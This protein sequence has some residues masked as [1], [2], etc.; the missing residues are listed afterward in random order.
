MTAR[1]DD[2]PDC[3]DA[4]VLAMLFEGHGVEDIKVR[5]GLR[6]LAIWNCLYRIC[7]KRHP[8]ATHA[9]LARRRVDAEF[10]APRSHDDE[11]QRVLADRGAR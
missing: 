6:W 11:I 9:R 8:F 10:A 7:R 2:I 5:T 4:V 1:P 3:T